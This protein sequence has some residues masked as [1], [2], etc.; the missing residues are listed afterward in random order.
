VKWLISFLVVA[1]GAVFGW[2]ALQDM[3]QLDPRAEVRRADVVAYG[4]VISSPRP[5]VVIDEIWKGCGSPDQSVLGRLSL[6]RLLI[7]RSITPWFASRHAC[8]H[9]GPL[10]P[11]FLLFVV[12]ALAY[13]RFHYQN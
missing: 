3:R 11:L 13:P 5:H 9:V 8:S 7:A 4:H 2:I 10:H 6:C 12:R 1:V